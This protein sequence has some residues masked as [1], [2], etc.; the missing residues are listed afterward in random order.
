MFF[1]F[2]ID[3]KYHYAKI[4]L[5]S[6]MMKKVSIRFTILS[7]FLTLAF[8]ILTIVNIAQYNFIEKMSQK[9]VSQQF[10]IISVKLKEKLENL[11]RFNMTSMNIF[12]AELQ[13]KTIHEILKDKKRYIKMYSAF[14]NGNSNIYSIYIGDNRNN[15]FEVINLDISKSLQKKHN[16]SKNDKWLLV[17]VDEYTKNKTTSIY[18][19]DLNLISQKVTKTLYQSS[20]RPWFKLALNS[21]DSIVRSDPYAFD[22]ISNKG[23]TYSKKINNN[24]VLGLDILLH[25]MNELLTDKEFL[26][27]VNS[28]IINQNKKVIASST[29]TREILNTILKNID[30]NNLED[31]HS[32]TQIYDTKYA[33]NIQKI[34]SDFIVSIANLTIISQTYRDDFRESAI[35][36]LILSVLVLPIVWYLSSFVV[37]PI[38]KLTKE[39]EKIAKREFENIEKVDSKI[40]E[41]SQLSNSMYDMANSIK[42]H[43]TELEQKVA[44]RT[45]ELKKLSIT[46]KL[47]DVYNRMKIDESLEAE[48]LRQNRYGN[49]FGI[50]IMDI[51]FFKSINDNYGHQAGDDVLKE[52]ANILKSRVRKTDIVG[53]WGGEEFIIICI[54]IDLEHL[55]KLAEKLRLEIEQTNF[56]HVDKKT[57]SFGVA[58]YKKDE[59]IEQFIN[60][61]DTALY[62]AKN[63]GR[64]RVEIG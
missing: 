21:N 47:T 39:N 64:N 54:E 10:N 13:D 6:F 59:K 25:D 50:I 61:A 19:K 11:N 48:V 58:L 1:N 55:V 16:T 24:M 57:A 30:L 34:D 62:K 40:A 45:K 32:K 33:Y 9:L 23:L 2:I 12:P 51:D 27:N 52:F 18:D 41:L 42:N 22:S 20:K 53:R 37:L 17:T 63:S 60:R 7:L 56:S 43:N 46:D 35:I 15:F 38:L 36:T 31:Y 8:A 3:F 5:W 29:P 49:K 4:L 14:L 44:E 28:Y 26:T